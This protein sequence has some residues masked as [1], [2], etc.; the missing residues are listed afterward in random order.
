MEV[1]GFWVINLILYDRL[2]DN[3]VVTDSGLCFSYLKSNVHDLIYTFSM[4]M[5][6]HILVQCS[7]GSCNH[8][9]A[10]FFIFYFLKFYQ[11]LDHVLVN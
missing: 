2:E 10:K 5:A 8:V 7:T 11:H 9:L 3:L 4:K 1:G 6:I